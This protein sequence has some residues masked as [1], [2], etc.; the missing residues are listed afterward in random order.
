MHVIDPQRLGIALVGL[1][2]L[3]K[4]HIGLNALR[5]E[6]AGRQ[7]QNGVKVAQVHQPSPQPRIHAV[8]AALRNSRTYR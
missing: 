4:Q 6:D 3:K 8:W 7:P 1:A 2:A 5:I